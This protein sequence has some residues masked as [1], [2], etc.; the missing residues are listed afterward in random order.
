MA[1]RAAHER[2]D[3][4]GVGIARPEASLLAGSLSL[5]TE[6]VVGA[7]IL[8]AFDI[9]VV[10]GRVTWIGATEICRD[11]VSAV[12]VRVTGE[13][14]MAGVGVASTKIDGCPSRTRTT[15]RSRRRRAGI[16]TILTRSLIQASTRDT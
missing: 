1:R 3:G 15:G 14:E 7:T 11:K 5:L 4:V 2:S 13:S 10:S 16:R 8:I 6:K 12:K 9:H